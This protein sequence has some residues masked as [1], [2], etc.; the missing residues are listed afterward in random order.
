MFTNLRYI[1]KFGLL[2]FSL[3]V[4]FMLA[5]Y[6]Q[7]VTQV[8]YSYPQVVWEEVVSGILALILVGTFVMIR[9]KRGHR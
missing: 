2:A 1:E 8:G 4:V 9:D 6:A 7:F 5:S 3:L